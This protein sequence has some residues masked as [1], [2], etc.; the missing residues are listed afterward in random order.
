MNKQLEHFESPIVLSNED[1]IWTRTLAETN[2]E[3]GRTVT[4]RVVPYNTIGNPT[5]KSFERF[6]PGSLTKTTTERANKIPLTWEHVSARG[7]QIGVSRGFQERSDGMYGAF[8]ISK[9]TDGNDA[10]QLL[11][12][13]ALHSGSLGFYPERTGTFTH[14]RS[15][16]IEIRE[17]RLDHYALIGGTPAYE[18]AAPLSLR[19]QAE[20]IEDQRRIAR[21]EQERHWLRTHS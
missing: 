8:Y 15:Q 21:L 5:R 11:K 12:D 7:P 3:A 19:E 17:A 13:G 1:E 9:T 20:D 18:D 2:D 10:L 14:N 4:V 16:G 6:A